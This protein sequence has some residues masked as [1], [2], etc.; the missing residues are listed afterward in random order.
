MA[1]EHLHAERLRDVSVPTL[2]SVGRQ[3]ERF[4]PLVDRVRTLP[5]LEV[6][7]LDAGHPVNAH[8]PAG[9]NAAVTRFL[10]AHAGGPTP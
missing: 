8:D 9:W 3:E 5:N 1:D 6:V 2:L 7:E 4:L 10:A